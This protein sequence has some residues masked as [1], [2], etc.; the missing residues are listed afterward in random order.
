MAPPNVVPTKSTKVAAPEK[1]EKNEVT[2]IHNETISQYQQNQ[3]H[4]KQPPQEKENNKPKGEAPHALP[5]K[6]G[7]K[8]FSAV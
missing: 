8:E 3:Q 2:V 7:N 5:T 6:A 1:V 4:N